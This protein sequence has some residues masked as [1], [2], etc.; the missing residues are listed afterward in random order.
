MMTTTGVHS[1]RLVQDDRQRGLFRVHRSL[2]TSPEVF[3][4]EYDRIFS[5]CWIYVGHES[6]IEKPGDYLRRVVAGRPLIFLRDSGGKVR[7]FFNSCTHRG[8]TICRQDS[9]NTRAFQCF[10]HAWTFDTQGQ[11][12]TVPDEDGYSPCFD[13]SE[14]A[15]RRPAAVDG[16]RGFWFVNYSRDADNLR[17]YLAD[18]ADYLDL[19]VDQA[20]SGMK[21]VP[22]TN[23]YSTKANWKLL[24]ENSF[25]TYH[26][27]PTHQT[28]FE[29][30]ASLG[31][32]MS[33]S[34]NSSSLDLG[35]G[36]AV[37][38]SDAPYGRP[39]AKWHPL[40]GEDSREEIAAIRKRLVNRFGEER[41]YRMADMIRNV[42]IF[43]TLFINDIQAI[44]IRYFE[45]AGPDLLET[46]AWTMAPGDESAAQLA[47]RI[48]S[49]LTFS[50]PA[51]F[52]IPD[53]VEAVESCQEGFRAC[54]EVEWSDIS[55][56]MTRAPLNRDELQMRT[57]WR[58]WQAK[59]AGE[60]PPRRVQEIETP[61]R[62]GD[63]VEA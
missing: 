47:R 30:I 5:Q 60:W 58:A 27:M 12:V 37:M 19:V 1:A 44:N 3:R 46:R 33:L 8:A 63:L 54:R 62:A 23:I 56:G 52:A 10:Y 39:I 32:T 43:P 15:L 28:Y 26:A 9:G 16:Y 7:V 57:F 50:G 20:E 61:I 51:G 53:D 17:S 25:D 14:R 49:F 38:Q 22:G 41:A 6:E 42:L 34:T 2:M 48:D 18:A 40:F 13:R 35:N 24:A 55:R 29:Y 11:L 36:H 45:P 59:M 31:G 21:V 4:Q